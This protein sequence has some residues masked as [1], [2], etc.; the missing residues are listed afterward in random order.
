MTQ[1]E[2]TLDVLE[3]RLQSCLQ[4]K[5]GDTGRSIRFHLRQGGE[6]F[7]PP[8][9]ARAVFT[10]K[11]PDGTVL[12][13]TCTRQARDFVYD[14]T[15][16][17]CSAVG[18]LECELRLYREQ[19]LLTCSRFSLEVL[20]TVYH[21]GDRLDSTSE[22]TELSNLAIRVENI[23][24]RHE[25]DLRDGLFQGEKG[26]PGEKGEPGEKGDPGIT[27]HIGDNGNWF[28]GDVDSGVAAGERWELLA[29]VEISEENACSL[30]SI[31]RDS[32]G[33]SFSC[34]QVY[35]DCRTNTADPANGFFG[36]CCINGTG[37]YN[38]GV[39]GFKTNA[40]TNSQYSRMANNI[41]FSLLGGGIRREAGN[42]DAIVRTTQK[43]IHEIELAVY[44]NVQRGFFGTLELWGV[45]V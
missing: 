45:R 44:D 22:A 27:P 41:A 13:N 9:D 26:D 30:V 43:D 7:L 2:L 31:S 4:A 25:E 17:T 36:W 16:Q 37:S 1:F 29:K 32:A 34:K 40:L 24:Q 39:H 20:D 6:S 12:Y 28:L 5:Y 42:G 14:F 21:D 33:A 15:P 11:K 10:A 35:L 18:T 8:A 3:Q 19:T 38:S 23:I